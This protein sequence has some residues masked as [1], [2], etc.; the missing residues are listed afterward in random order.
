[1]LL[2]GLCP[3]RLCI[4]LLLCSENPAAFLAIVCSSMVPVSRGSSLRDILCPTGGF[5]SSSSQ[6]QNDFKEWVPYNRF[7]QR[8]HSINYKIEQMQRVGWP[9]GLASSC[10]LPYLW[11]ESFLWRT[12]WILSWACIPATFGWWN[13]YSSSAS[14]FL[15]WCVF[16]TAGFA[17]TFQQ[18]PFVVFGFMN[19]I[20]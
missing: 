20:I 1:M 15:G 7:V 16:S 5:P 2:F 13:Y 9:W 6:Q 4:H 18:L 14:L 19:A 12:Q 17:P 11:V 3:P 8:L 10:W